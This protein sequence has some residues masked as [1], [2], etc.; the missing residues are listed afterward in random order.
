MLRARENT[1]VITMKEKPIRAVFLERFFRLV[2]TLLEDISN[3]EVALKK[4]VVNYFYGITSFR[5]L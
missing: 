1:R 4:I 3:F 2:K 5:L